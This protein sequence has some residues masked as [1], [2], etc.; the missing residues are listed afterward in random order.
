MLGLRIYTLQTN[1]ITRVIASNDIAEIGKEGTDAELKAIQNGA[2]SFGREKGE[3]LI[4]LPLHDR[5]GEYI[6][7][8]RVRLKSYFGET[9]D[10][11]LTRARMIVKQMQDQIGTQKDLL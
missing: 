1:D 11:A 3:V 8:V 7:A 10:H 4:T 5:N 6:A 9:Q 2:T